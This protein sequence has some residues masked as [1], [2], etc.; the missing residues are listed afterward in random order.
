MTAIAL[1]EAAELRLPQNSLTCAID[2]TGQYYRVPIACIND[3]KTYG[4]NEELQR[5]MSK[6]SPK[7]KNLK[8]RI[9]PQL[10]GLCSFTL[11]STIYVD[12]NS[13]PK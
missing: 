10:I 4:R 6:K 2:R 13:L 1:V 5:M 11:T 7:A 12:Q 9:K 3:P 8:V